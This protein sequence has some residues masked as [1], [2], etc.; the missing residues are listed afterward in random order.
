VV[1]LLPHKCEALSSN[2]NTVKK[3]KKLL[4]DM[5][6]NTNEKTLPIHWNTS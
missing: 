1:E 4:K 5:K 3:E 2:P 6:R